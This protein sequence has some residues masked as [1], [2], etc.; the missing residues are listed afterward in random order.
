MRAFINASGSGRRESHTEAAHNV[1]QSGYR[2]MLRLIFTF[3]FSLSRSLAHETR[4]K[5]IF[6]RV[7]TAAAVDASRECMYT[8]KN[9]ATTIERMSEREREKFIIFSKCLRVTLIHK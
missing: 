7:D 5:N 4:K 2:E 6:A 3:L 9:L 8:K 1:A